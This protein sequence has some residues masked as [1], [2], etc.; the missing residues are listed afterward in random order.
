MD[1]SRNGVQKERKALIH[2]KLC[3]LMTPKQ[4]EYYDQMSLSYVFVDATLVHPKFKI[5]F[6]TKANYDEIDIETY[7]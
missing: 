4:R 7:K 6:M 1:L 5:D 3:I 2:L